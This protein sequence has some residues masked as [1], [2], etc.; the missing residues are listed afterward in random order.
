M[1][2]QGCRQDQGDRTKP[3]VWH[4]QR[5]KEVKDFDLEKELMKG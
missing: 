5:G 4:S 1:V 2:D 3:R